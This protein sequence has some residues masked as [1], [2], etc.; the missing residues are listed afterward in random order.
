MHIT[1]DRRVAKFGPKHTC[2]FEKDKDLLRLWFK[3]PPCRRGKD[4]MTSNDLDLDACPIVGT[5]RPDAID[6][7]WT[8]IKQ[9]IDDCD[10]YLVIIAGRYG[11][12]GP[13]E[14]SFTQLEYEHAI[15]QEK[16][17]LAFL[18]KDPGKLPADDTEQDP[19]LA[20]KL[21]DFRNLARKKMVRHWTT[22]SDLGSAV[23][24]SIIKLIK[25]PAVGWVKTLQTYSHPRKQVKRC[26]ISGAR[27]MNS[28]AKSRR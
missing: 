11:S 7:Q 17:V 3:R 5:A 26:W 18:H 1:P 21:D 24:R 4:Y 14:K 13:G 25:S 15:S 20:K 22:P 23:S 9:V 8:L 19:Q 6:D 10:Y 12:T 16:P 28:S 27:L 2:R